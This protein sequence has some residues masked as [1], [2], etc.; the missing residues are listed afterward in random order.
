MKLRMVWLEG[1][2]AAHGRGGLDEGERFLSFPVISVSQSDVWSCFRVHVCIDVGSRAGPR[3]D[4]C[5][6]ISSSCQLA[7]V[8]FSRLC[9]CLRGTNTVRHRQTHPQEQAILGTNLA[10]PFS[11]L[12]QGVRHDLQWTLDREK[13][14]VQGCRPRSW[15]LTIHSLSVCRETRCPAILF[16]SYA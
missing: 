5:H 8:P 9:V 3:L 1:G 7:S 4:G 12:F 2:D 10:R 6:L 15:W 13:I 14:D 16:A 11:T